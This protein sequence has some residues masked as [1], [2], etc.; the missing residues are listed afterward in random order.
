MSSRTARRG[1][2]TPIT[3][4]ASRRVP[5]A[6]R[7]RPMTAQVVSVQPAMTTYSLHHPHQVRHF[8]DHAAGR[9]RVGN[10]G[11]GRAGPDQRF[12]LAVGGGCRSVRSDHLVSLAL[13]P[14]GL[15]GFG[16]NSVAGRL[17][18]PA[19]RA[20]APA[21]RHLDTA[22]GDRA[23]NP[24]AWAHRGPAPCLGVRRPT[25]L[26]HVRMPSVSNTAR[27]GPPA[28]MPVPGG[29]AHRGAGAVAAER[30]VVARLTQ[31]DAD[32]T[33]FGGFGPCGSPRHFAPCRGRS[34]PAPFRADHDQRGS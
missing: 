3:T 31:R 14:P 5:L 2:R 29:A 4:Q 26:P 33:A 22:R 7:A 16:G 34:R 25:I 15:M 20:G 28:M 1:S 13:R 10:L 19:H 8:S 12:A 27:I 32:E 6:L 21:G 11:D 17:A 30:V 24:G 18:L 23:A 9:R